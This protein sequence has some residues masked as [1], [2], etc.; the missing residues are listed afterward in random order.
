MP[1]CSACGST[2]DSEASVSAHKGSCDSYKAERESIKMLASKLDTGG[3]ASVYV[4]LV[5]HTETSKQYY[6]V[7]QTSHPRTRAKSHYHSGE[8]SIPCDEGCPCPTSNYEICEV[9]ESRA[10]DEGEKWQIERD[11][12]NSWCERK[13]NVYGGK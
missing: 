6:Y 10:C 3:Q 8:I 13:S 4:L 11:V 12:Y 5:Q 1:S 7:G 9:I 2:F